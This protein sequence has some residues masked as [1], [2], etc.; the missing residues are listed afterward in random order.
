M[1]LPGNDKCADCGRKLPSWAS[2]NLGVIICM[3]CAGC[4]RGLGV[5]ISQVR[6]VKMDTWEDDWLRDF[7]AMGGNKVRNAI[8]EAKLKKRDKLTEDNNGYRDE[9]IR[10][11]Y[12]S[13]LYYRR[14]RKSKEEAKRKK[15]SRKTGRRKKRYE[16]SESEEESEDESEDEEEDEDEDEEE[17]EEEVE[18]PKPRRRRGKAKKVVKTKR[19]GK[20]ISSKPKRTSN[21]IPAFNE[22]KVSKP[23]TNGA[24]W[25]NFD[26][27]FDEQPQPEAQPTAKPTTNGAFNAFEEEEDFEADFESGNAQGTE[28]STK[29]QSAAQSAPASGGSNLLLS[30]FEES[31]PKK[32]EKGVSSNGTHV[33]YVPKST[34]PKTDIMAL[35]NDGGAQMGGRQAP[36]GQMGQMGM[37][38]QYG[39]MNY[40]QRAMTMP[41][42]QQQGGFGGQYGGQYAPQ[43]RGYPA[44]GMMQ[45]QYGYRQQGYPQ[46]YGMQ[47]Q[48]YNYGGAQSMGMGMQNRP[49]SVP[50]VSM[51]KPQP[52]KKAAADP[53]A[54]LAT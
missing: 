40:G 51:A 14:G 9:F 46:Q 22:M 5:H 44:Q 47:Q 30:V 19:S 53:F 45:Q 13:K 25:A 17:E 20:K 42:V 52:E 18:S 3:D 12:E 33:K 37:Y 26:E 54:F 32:E 41:R 50:P 29:A 36:M 4:H 6:S 49:A 15:G 31:Q 43:G 2:K 34:K 11:K 10:N 28:S 39:G 8:Y 7:L 48:G 24:S 23:S 27:A 16:E 35:F 21:P 1:K 38:P